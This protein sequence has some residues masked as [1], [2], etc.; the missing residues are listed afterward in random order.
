MALP[1]ATC[2]E[3]AYETDVGDGQYYCQACFMA[4]EDELQAPSVSREEPQLLGRRCWPLHTQAVEA[5][6]E[7][8]RRQRL[9]GADSDSDD[10][11]PGA[12][13]LA[14]ARAA[15]AKARASGSNAA[16]GASSDSGRLAVP[17]VCTPYSAALFVSPRALH[18]HVTLT[19]G[20]LH[21]HKDRD[22]NRDT[23]RALLFL[24]TA[25]SSTRARVE[26]FSTSEPGTCAAKTS[27][28]K[29]RAL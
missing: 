23:N 14:A 12:S 28:R 20:T 13:S 18:K 19:R 16:P 8:R 7:Q 1:C 22:T 6:E 11:E 26:A 25:I 4:F 27:S 17:R 15:R 5:A 29:L 2:G 24:M 9:A 21:A 10:A 3:P